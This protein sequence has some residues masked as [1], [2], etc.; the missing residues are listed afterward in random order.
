MNRFS[1]RFA[2]TL[3]LAVAVPATFA[4]GCGGKAS[5]TKGGSTK[6]KTGGTAS[7]NSS[8]ATMEGSTYM[9]QTCDGT[10]EGQGFCADTSTIIFCSGGNWYS[11]D[12]SQLSS[13]PDC[14]E[15]SNG[16]VD[17]YPASDF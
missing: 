3:C 17:C 9:S 7:A 10:A 8:M 13:T 15:D 12:C 6:D 4:V 11:L 1:L 14:G 16:D 2:L 5:F